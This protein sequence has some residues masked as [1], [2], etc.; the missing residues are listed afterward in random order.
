MIEYEIVFEINLLSGFSFKK[1]SF[2]LKKEPISSTNIL[3]HSDF[4]MSLKDFNVKVSNHLNGN[5]LD[6]SDETNLIQKNIEFKNNN[7]DVT[8]WWNSVPKYKKKV[9]EEKIKEAIFYNYLREIGRY[10]TVKNINILRDQLLEIAKNKGFNDLHNICFSSLSSV[11]HEEKTLKN[12]QYYFSFNSYNFPNKITSS[13]IFE[14]KEL[15]GISAGESKGELQDIEFLKKTNIDN[16]KIIL[17]TKSLSP[18]IAQHFDKISGIVSENGGILSHLAIIAR[19]QKI[20]VVI[21]FSIGQN[22]INLGDML[23]IDGN[24]GRVEKQ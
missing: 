24:N 23:K 7:E 16:K 15:V 14:E 18:Q 20:P 17:Y 2:L 12:K 9:L 22:N 21:G 10:L 1:L 5:S 8:I 6:I 3:A 19:E 4:F 11:L 13:F